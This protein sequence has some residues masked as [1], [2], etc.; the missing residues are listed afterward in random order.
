MKYLKIQNKGELDIRLVA[1]MGGSTKTNDRY[2]IGKFGTGLKYTLAFLFRNNLEFKIFSGK[3]NVDISLV[4]ENIANEDFEIICIN[5]NRTSITTKMGLEW[6]AWMILRELWCNAL[7]EGDAIKEIGNCADVNLLEGN[8]GATT[9]FIQINDEIKQ[10]LDN[11]SDYFIINETPLFE[12]SNYGIYQNKGKLKLYKQGVLIYQ[13]PDMD[14]LLKYDIKNASI[15]ELREFKGSVSAEMFSALRSPNKETISYFFNNVKEEHYEGSAMDYDW[16]SNFASI[17]KDTIGDRKIGYYSSSSGN[18]GGVSENI[19]KVINLPKK[20]YKALTKSF[21]GIGA[22]G[23]CDEKNEF[24][25]VKD[26]F[27]EE[28]INF[29]LMNLIDGGY[30]YDTDIKFITGTFAEKVF[31]GINRNKKQVL[32]SNNLLNEPESTLSYL[33]VEKIE[34]IKKGSSDKNVLAD[35]FIKLYT[36]KIIANI[37]QEQ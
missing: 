19:N 32:I 1:L 37:Q 13:H 15:N 21:E 26:L 24:Y 29:V 9:F 4:T 25:E 5:N 16:F 2:K 14:S 34:A 8:E 6:S 23:M 18:D 12:D 31:A 7:D 35:H 11:W 10:V 17:W 30:E 27:M 22:I 28:K 20:I 33:L 3:E 36:D